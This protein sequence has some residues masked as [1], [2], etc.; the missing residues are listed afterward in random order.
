[1]ALAVTSTQAWDQVALQSR[2]I[3]DEAGNLLA[4]EINSHS[5]DGAEVAVAF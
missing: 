2:E 1:M 5:A 4:Y 3:L